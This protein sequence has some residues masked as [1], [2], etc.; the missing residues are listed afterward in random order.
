MENIKTEAFSLD[1]QL[2][3]TINISKLNFDYLGNSKQTKVDE[4]KN[5]RANRTTPNQLLN[6][7][8]GQNIHCKN[9]KY[10]CKAGNKFVEYISA[11]SAS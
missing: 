7:Q 3:E 5:S 6:S 8:R 11:T 4:I 1:N 10:R 2:I 9:P